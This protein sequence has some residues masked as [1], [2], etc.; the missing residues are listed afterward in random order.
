MATSTE[1]LQLSRALPP[2]PRRRI[3]GALVAPGRDTL[4]MLT[5]FAREYGDVTFLRLGGERCYFI[6]HPQYVRD[7]LVTNQRNFTK[8]RGLERAKLLLGE[9]LLTSEGQHHLRQ[10]RLI[11]PAFHRERIAG[12]GAVMVDYADRM[13]KR[14]RDGETFDVAKEMMRV[15]L[16]IAGKT[17]FDTDV[18]SKADEV[19]VAV[20]EVLEGFW[21]N[22]LPGAD[23]L[24]RLPI[25]P[26][27]RATHARHR[28]DALIY[29]MIA[30]RRASGRD[31]GDLLSM[32][33]AAVDDEEAGGGMTDQQVRDEAMTLL[34]AGHETTANALTWT[35]YLLSQ[36][37]T[38]EATLHAE[39]D[40]VLGGR[41]PSTADLPNLPYTRRVLAESMRLYPPAWLI[42]RRAIGAY[43][44]DDYDVPPR[45]II[46]MSPFVMH[47]DA[48]FFPDPLTFN[49]ERWTAEFEATLPKFAYFP[50]GG[51]ARQ[52]IGEQ[53][54]WMEGVLVL[55]TVAQRWRLQLAPGQRI[56]PQPLV[57]LRAKYGVKMTAIAYAARR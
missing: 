54:A 3:F 37:P 12:Y 50:F 42:G 45:A 41:T 34:L 43:R 1:S 10:R 23:F 4:A 33:I 46:F 15:T 5:G 55:A 51:G 26:L 38:A 17:L 24:Q 31:H 36:N 57:T 39:L 25:P 20:T 28:L 14:W 18:E 27:R 13:R 9:G 52:C 21:L 47:R 53:F 49:P 56:V 29:Q 35:L 8:S 40:R 7:V 44:I 48:R 22:L 6:N 19:G 30:D 32:L 16:A 11:Q 2:G